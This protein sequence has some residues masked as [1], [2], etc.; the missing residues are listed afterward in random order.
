M[1]YSLDRM[2]LVTRI[3]DE[4]EVRVWTKSLLTAE[5]RAIKAELNPR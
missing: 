2:R 3:P 1:H 5:I 4:K